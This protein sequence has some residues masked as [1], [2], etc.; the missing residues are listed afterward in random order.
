[1]IRS[2]QSWFWNFFLNGNKIER[3]VESIKGWKKVN[4]QYFK[5]TRVSN[6]NFSRRQKK[7]KRERSRHGAAL[8]AAGRAPLHIVSGNINLTFLIMYKDGWFRLFTN[9]SEIKNPSPVTHCVRLH[10]PD[11]FNLNA[12]HFTF[13]TAGRSLFENLLLHFLSKV[14]FK[15]QFFRSFFCWSCPV[16]HYSAGLHQ[17]GFSSRTTFQ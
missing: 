6:L 14:Y 13:L 4:I 11:F 8:A 7:C 16:S 10:Q 9:F 5:R 15:S 17:A 3:K 2:H 12:Q 1:M